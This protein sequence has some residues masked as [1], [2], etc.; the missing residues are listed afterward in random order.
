[1]SVLLE[2][3]KRILLD[4]EPSARERLVQSWLARALGNKERIKLIK[5]VLYQIKQEEQDEKTKAQV[6]HFID[7]F[8]RP[9]FTK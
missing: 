7:I 1:M 2:E 6:E 3:Y 5:S 9:N 8:F 4:F